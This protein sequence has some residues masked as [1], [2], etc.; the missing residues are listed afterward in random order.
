MKRIVVWLLL[1]MLCLSACVSEKTETTAPLMTESQQNTVPVT[2]ETESAAAPTDQ[3]I[4]FVPIHPVVRDYL[5]SLSCTDS[6]VTV[7]RAAEL[8]EIKAALPE[9][10][11]SV[12]TQGTQQTLRA[13]YRLEKKTGPVQNGDL[14]ILE[15]GLK[16][17]SVEE[18]GDSYLIAADGNS[19]FGEIQSQ[20]IGK[21]LGDT[22]SFIL[23]AE[24]TDWLLAAYDGKEIVY[25]IKDL[26]AVTDVSE[27]TK[28]MM[29]QNG[30][31]NAAEL[32]RYLI[33]KNLSTE[34]TE[35]KSRAGLGFLEA[36]IRCC[37]YSVSEEDRAAISR[38]MKES[39]A[40]EAASL[41]MSLE[42][43]WKLIR[44]NIL[45]FELDE[46]MEKAVDYLTDYTI[47]TALFVGA[48]AEQKQVTLNDEQAEAMW[49]T[50]KELF[51]PAQ[52]AEMKYKCLMDLFLP[53][54]DPKLEDAVWDLAI[55]RRSQET[56][57]P[58][59]PAEPK[60]LK[61]DA[62][63][64]EV[65]KYINDMIYRINIL[66]RRGEGSELERK[67]MTYYPGAQ[68]DYNRGM[69][70]VFLTVEEEYLKQAAECFEL[71]IG[72][73]EN[74]EYQARDY[75]PAGHYD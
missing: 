8:K 63:P 44:P 41:Q 67:L 29:S 22:G 20:L 72:R 75:V 54:C 68:F 14:V 56:L 5:A 50:K 62:S 59:V 52:W 31:R 6:H 24:I 32:F 51:P 38:N 58:T 69:V 60:P 34:K 64:N 65:Y 53:L 43:Y 26:Y 42:H 18:N 49:Q 30:F 35:S 13:N 25:R 70:T 27:T 39:Y 17:L 48:A 15:A 21:E 71:V 7:F 40:A 36:A 2:R 12:L 46:D 11:F 28:E 10:K 4:S 45:Y 74:V 73:F 23:P 16:D 66:V 61:A 57:P 33:D 19:V 47:K 55:R 37:D 1:L 9:G 3:E